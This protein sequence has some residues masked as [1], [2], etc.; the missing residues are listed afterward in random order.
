M[1]IFCD[2]LDPRDYPEY[3]NDPRISRQDIEARLNAIAA[4][5]APWER[6]THHDG[7]VWTGY[8]LLD[9]AQMMPEDLET[10]WHVIIGEADFWY[11]AYQI[12]FGHGYHPVYGTCLCTG[13]AELASACVIRDRNR[14]RAAFLQSQ[15]PPD[16]AWTW[17]GGGGSDETIEE[18]LSGGRDLDDL[19][20]QHNLD[21]GEPV[22]QSRSQSRWSVWAYAKDKSPEEERKEL[23]ER[24]LTEF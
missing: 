5:N 9:E 20:E 7:S 1:T 16:Y 22:K 4:L 12:D 11:E 10:F 15:E 17:D 2:Q 3:L 18:M 13:K 6:Y 21:D 8:G 23:S 14:E 19:I 24:S